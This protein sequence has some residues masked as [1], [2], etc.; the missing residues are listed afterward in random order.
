M[1]DTEVEIYLN[2][3]TNRMVK[4]GTFAYRQMQ[5][6]LALQDRLGEMKKMPS[7]FKPTAKSESIYKKSSDIKKIT[8]KTPKIKA[9]A[10]L[11]VKKDE[12]SDSDSDISCGSL[13]DG[14]SDSDKDGDESGEKKEETKKSTL[15]PKVE[16]ESEDDYTYES[17]DIDNAEFSYDYQ[18]DDEDEN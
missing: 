17:V 16:E 6:N 13:F 14:W 18:T 10:E 11:F 12:S 15:F 4:K 5:R 8:P 7:D 3:L 2:P 1:S 9:K